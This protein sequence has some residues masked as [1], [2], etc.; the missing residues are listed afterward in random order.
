LCGTQ[1][2]S[3][4]TTIGFI[5]FGRIAQAAL[6]RFVAFGV[7]HAIYHT[8]SQLDLTTHTALVS[9]LPSLETLDHVSLDVLAQQSDLIVVLT[10]GGKE[11]YHLV[12]DAFLSKCKKTASLVNCARGSVVDSEALARALRQEKIWSAGLDV[13]E[14]EPDVGRYHPLVKEP[15]YAMSADLRL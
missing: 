13:V 11:T 9:S 2:S 15:R 12:D 1:L 3:P 4:S 6:R 5:G 8:R 14:G 7:R 10:P